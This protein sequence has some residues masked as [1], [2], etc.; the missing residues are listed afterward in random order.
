MF[1]LL[2]PQNNNDH[3]LVQGKEFLLYEELSK[4]AVL[5]HLKLLETKKSLKLFFTISDYYNLDF[6]RMREVK[7]GFG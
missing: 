7:Y 6:G 1:N 3:N 5:P 4:R 2:K